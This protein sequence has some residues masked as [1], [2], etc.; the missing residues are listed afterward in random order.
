MQRLIMMN[1]IV[2]LLSIVVEI[3]HFVKSTLI[4]DQNSI[5]NVC[6]DLLIYVKHWKYNF[7]FLNIVYIKYCRYIF[8]YIWILAKCL[9][10]FSLPFLKPLLQERFFSSTSI[11]WHTYICVVHTIII[12]TYKYLEQCFT[13]IIHCSSYSSSCNFSTIFN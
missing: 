2:I 13:S 3:Y 5:L 9:E 8:S 12:F 1:E 4:V 7:H 10:G 6:R 11:L